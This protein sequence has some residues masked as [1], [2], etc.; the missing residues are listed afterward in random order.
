MCDSGS[1]FWLEVPK[2]AEEICLEVRNQNTDVQTQ[3]AQAGN[4]RN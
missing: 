2:L 1:E 3:A 4:L